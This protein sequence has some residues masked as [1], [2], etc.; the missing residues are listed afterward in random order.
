MKINSL[1]DLSRRAHASDTYEVFTI[2]VA[3]VLSG[4]EVKT[5][6]AALEKLRFMR[7]EGDADGCGE[8][9]LVAMI[10]EY[11][12][13]SYSRRICQSRNQ[14]LYGKSGI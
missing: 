8:K 2:E 5:L 13:D 6:K 1:A 9:D 7:D 11:G 14:R 10:N 12:S 4:T 3:A